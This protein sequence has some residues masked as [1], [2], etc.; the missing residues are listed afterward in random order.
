MVF[1][2]GYTVHYLDQWIYLLSYPFFQ[3]DVADR[4]IAFNMFEIIHT[5]A[6]IASVLIF[7]FGLVLGIFHLW[8][9][10]VPGLSKRNNYYVAAAL[11]IFLILILAFQDLFTNNCI[12]SGCNLILSFSQLE[13][14][15][16]YPIQF[17]PKLYSY[18]NFVLLWSLLNVLML[19]AIVS[20]ALAFTVVSSE[21]KKA[22]LHLR[23]YLYFCLI[24]FYIALSNFEPMVLG[25]LLVQILVF[26][27]FIFFI[28][29]FLV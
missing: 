7:A 9:F 27:F 29:L 5:K 22:A 19:F 14:N 13:S 3:L 28:V 21:T 11:I 15:L 16:L 12:A 26:E 8:W 23:F 25:V 4:L 6:L 24:I 17:E 1:F 10:I 2:V 20:I 18:I